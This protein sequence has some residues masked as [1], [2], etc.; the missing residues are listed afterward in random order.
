MAGIGIDRE[1]QAATAGGDA[2]DGAAGPAKDH[3]GDMRAVCRR[4]PSRVGRAANQ[5]GRLYQIGAGETRVRQI[6]RAVKY[7]NGDCGIAQGFCPQLRQARNLRGLGTRLAGHVT[8]VHLYLHCGAPERRTR[9]SETEIIH[10]AFDL[11]RIDRCAADAIRT[12]LLSGGNTI[13]ASLRVT[14][15]SIAWVAAVW[16]HRPMNIQAVA[17][18]RRRAGA[19]TWANWRRRRHAMAAD[20]RGACRLDARAGLQYIA[21]GGRSTLNR[22]GYVR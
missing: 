22:I 10:Q 14:L 5:R 15:G 4:D 17:S 19:D 13:A 21:S 2:V 16:D 11:D 3:A 9:L 8:A 1:Q 18:S 6:D 20:R 12:A 7:G